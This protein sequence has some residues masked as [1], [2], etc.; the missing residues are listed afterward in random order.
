MQVREPGSFQ[1]CLGQATRYLRFSCDILLVLRQLVAV[2]QIP[3]I[4]DGMFQVI[5]KLQQLP[6]VVP[7]SFRICTIEKS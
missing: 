2:F 1:I 7:S 6:I 3:V 4:A 5:S